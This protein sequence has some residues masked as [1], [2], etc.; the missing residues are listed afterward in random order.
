[1]LPR[2]V[3]GFGEMHAKV[4]QRFEEGDL[5]A[6][7]PSA[8]WSTAVFLGLVG[9]ALTGGAV[10]EHRDY[11]V[12]R[13][14]GVTASAR[15]FAVHQANWLPRSRSYVIVDFIDLQGIGRSATL[16]FRATGAY[17]PKVGDSQDV[18]YD[19]LDE[20]TPV[21]SADRGPD[22]RP[23]WLLGGAASVCV[24]GGGLAAALRLRRQREDE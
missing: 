3:G 22:A 15:V 2:R 13:E 19:P 8:R 7:W 10:Q 9:L 23:M 24:I 16:G 17:V 1:M 4:R 14:R 18:L 20:A 12:L 11:S 5:L 6:R 21:V